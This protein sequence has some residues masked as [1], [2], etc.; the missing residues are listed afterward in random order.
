[1]NEVVTWLLDA[2]LFADRS[3]GGRAV[4]ALLPALGT[5]TVVVGLAR[6]G[7]EV[8]AEIAAARGWPLDVLAVRK[9]RHPY[10]PEY[11]LGAVTPGGDGVYV[12]ARNGLTEAEFA[13]AVAAAR[14]E[15]EELDH[16]LHADHPALDRADRPVVL[17]DDGLAT[18][19][20]MIAAA[21]WARA[22]GATP[23]V[24]AVP[25]AARPSVEHVLP[26][27]DLLYCPHVRADLYA[28]GIW[29]ADFAQVSDGDV[30]RLLDAATARSSFT[31]ASRQA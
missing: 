22:G 8:A 26:E 1:M 19:A 24:A 29:Y 30:L 12:R 16:L 31:S 7:V 11:A 2:P 10:Q 5:Q 6:G 4:T 17:V 15:A 28:V 14:H 25:V 20:T 3:E 21:R 18:G 27:V 9:V 23:V 13:D